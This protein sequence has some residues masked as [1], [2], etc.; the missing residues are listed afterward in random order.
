MN[1]DVRRQTIKKGLAS[2][3]NRQQ[4]V[5]A[6]LGFGPEAITINDSLA[7]A[8]AIAPQIETLKTNEVVS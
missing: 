3:K 8:F 5:L 4:D 1:N 2:S 6:A 7:D